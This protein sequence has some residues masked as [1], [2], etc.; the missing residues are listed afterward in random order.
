MRSFAEPDTEFTILRAEYK[1]G[2]GQFPD[3]Y[4]GEPTGIVVCDECGRRADSVDEIPH[5]TTPGDE[6]GQRFVHFRWYLDT[7][8]ADR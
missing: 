6:C 5:R 1:L 4:E 8:M 7:A 3:C 2:R